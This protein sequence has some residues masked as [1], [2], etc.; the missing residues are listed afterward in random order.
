[1]QLVAFRTKL[2][3]VMRDWCFLVV[4]VFSAVFVSR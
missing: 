3:L 1:M 2:T 4:V